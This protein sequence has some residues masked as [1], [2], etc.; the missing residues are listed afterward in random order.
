MPSFMYN[1]NISDYEYEDYDDGYD[2]EYNSDVNY[3]SFDE[4]DESLFNNAKYYKCSYCSKILDN[5][6]SLVKHELICK[7]LSHNFTKTSATSSNP[8]QFNYTN[9]TPSSSTMTKCLICKCKMSSREYLM[10]NCLM[11]DG[12]NQQQS[13]NSYNKSEFDNNKT[14][15]QSESKFQSDSFLKD[16]QKTKKNKQNNRNNSASKKNTTNEQ[17]ETKSSSKSTNFTGLKR[18]KM[19]SG[20][21]IK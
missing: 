9:E 21:N 10:H 19:K 1:E 16:N 3:D 15:N 6:E 2:E 20:T 7:R 18:E 14:N 17:T 8:T 4:D 11:K 12:T 13:Q 5:E